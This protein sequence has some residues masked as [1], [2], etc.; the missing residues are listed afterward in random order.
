MKIG[1]YFAKK[2]ISLCR[3]IVRKICLD[4]NR[5]IKYTFELKG[6]RGLKRYTGFVVAAIFLLVPLYAFCTDTG[7]EKAK[8]QVQ[9]PKHVPKPGIKSL[10]PQEPKIPQ[11]Y[12][13][14]QKAYDQYWG[15]IMKKDF[16]KA[17]DMESAKYKKSH[18]YAK[19]KYEDMLP[20]DMK[21]TAV[22]ALEVEKINKKEVVVK[23]NYYFALGALKSVRPFSD[24]WT[25]EGSKWVHIPSEGQFRK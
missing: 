22:M 6:G 19:G 25:K 2:S 15:F 21:M 11:E 7:G 24:K 17:Y 10:K 20:K 13:E 18:P 1:P 12:K 23:G 4:K 8:S 9:A 14:L 5:V 3:E 16:K